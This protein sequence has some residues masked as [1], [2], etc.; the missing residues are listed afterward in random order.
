MPRHDT[1]YPPNEEPGT[2]GRRLS[3]AVRESDAAGLLAEQ[4]PVSGAGQQP[5][6]D[7]PPGRR[8]PRLRW[9][10]GR[11][12]ATLL[13]TASVA[14]L[15]WFWWQ[16]ANVTAPVSPTSSVNATVNSEETV[17]EP[18]NWPT[19]GTDRESGRIGAAAP[20]KI[21]VHVAG[22][23][24]RAGV[25]ELPEGSRLHEAIAAAGGSAA[26]A[27]PDQLNL[28]AVLEDGQKVLVPLQGETASASG[29]GD[30]AVG[31][32]GSRVGPSGGGGP[33]PAGVKIN[34]NTAEAEELATLPRVGTVLAQRIV[35]WRTQHGRFQ[36]VE[37]LDA[38]E[39][40]G[41]K[42]LAALLPLVRV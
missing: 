18:D 3:F 21:T 28:A 23:V 16:A 38:V 26:D 13:C 12:A 37:E 36:R 6:P 42:L 9:R 7:D 19:T 41:P 8:G 24:L 29:G 30:P 15:S 14:L 5:T 1:D 4:P 32:T 39:G 10:T 33:H 27:D 40:I 11:Q 25:V 35:D 22:A 34:L 20:G 31:D 17:P 2:A